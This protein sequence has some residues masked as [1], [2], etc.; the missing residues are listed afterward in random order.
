MYYSA[1]L[2]YFYYDRSERGVSTYMSF[3]IL[4]RREAGYSL[5]PSRRRYD[6][7]FKIALEN[8]QGEENGESIS[9]F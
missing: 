8:N 7:G 2:N 5:D 4:R 1:N 9:V 3:D 6:L